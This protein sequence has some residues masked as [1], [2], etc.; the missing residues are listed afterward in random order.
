MSLFATLLEAHTGTLVERWAHGFREG[1]KPYS[2]RL[3]EQLRHVLRALSLSLQHGKV[4]VPDTSSGPFVFDPQGLVREYGLLSSTLLELAEKTGTPV[5]VPEMR[6]FTEFMSALVA[7]GVASFA[8]LHEELGRARAAAA[9]VSRSEHQRA[10]EQ[11]D[12]LH[13]LALSERDVSLVQTLFMQAPALMCVVEG[14]DLSVTFANEAWRASMGMEPLG[15]ALRAAV[16]TVMASGEPSVLNEQPIARAQGQTVYLNL[17]YQPRCNAAGQVS[18]VLMVGSDVSSQVRAREQRVVES[19]SLRR[20]EEHLRRVLEVAVAGTWELDVAAGTVV[21]DS[22]IRALHGYPPGDDLTLERALVPFHPEDRPQAHAALERLLAGEGDGRFQLEYRATDA[23]GQLRWLEARGRVLFDASGAARRVLGTSV[24]ITSRKQAE[25]TREGLLAALE[26]QPLLPVVVLEGPQHVVK[27][28]NAGYREQIAGGRNIVGQP[29]L[30]AYPHLAQQG[31]DVMLDQVR[32]T[33]VPSVS[34]NLSVALVGDHGRLEERYFDLL[35]QPVKGPAGEVDMLL[36]ISLEVTSLVQS[37]RA[38]ERS[39][40]AEKERAEFERQLLGIVGHDLGNPIAAMK[41]GIGLLE[42]QEGLD[43]GSRKVVERL[44]T[45]LAGMMRQVNDLLDVSEARVGGGLSITRELMDLHTVTQEIA[46]EV[47]M[48]YPSRELEVEHE[49]SGEGSWDPQRIAQ[50]A[51][52]LISNALKHSP[53]DSTVRV[54]TRAVGEWVELSV[55]NQ[56]TPI[57]PDVLPVLFE[58]MHRVRAAAEPLGRSVGLGLYVVKH[59]VDALGGTIVVTSNADA[60]TA[61]TL[62]FPRVAA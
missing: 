8:R 17:V 55:S 51:Q 58:P 14:Q 22:A 13:D 9:H 6:V 34:R 15:A 5:S 52:N 53:P 46:E 37:T 30:S 39:A 20:S 11:K 24:D 36:S 25:L 16:K 44:K 38:L 40:A 42:R 12:R 59:I 27:L 49:G 54:K 50:V 56:G 2:A 41:L 35:V 4:G 3:Q 48:T 32:A 43:P 7:E 61:F 33:G 23:I 1:A 18:G 21:A 10:V 60:G 29:V 28:M 19:A 62:R 26:A 45:T 47:Q 31:F 57:P